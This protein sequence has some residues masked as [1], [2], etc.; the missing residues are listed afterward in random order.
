MTPLRVRYDW[1]ICVIGLIYACDMSDSSVHHDSC[2]CAPWLRHMC[3]M[4]YSHRWHGSLCAVCVCARVRVCVIVCE[5]ERVRVH[6]SMQGARKNFHLCSARE[7]F[8]IC[9]GEESFWRCSGKFFSPSPCKFCCTP[10][11]GISLSAH[12]QPDRICPAGGRGWEWGRTQGR[13]RGNKHNMHAR[14]RQTCHTHHSFLPLNHVGPSYYSY[15]NTY[16]NTRACNSKNTNRLSF[17][18][19]P[20]L[21]STHTQLKY[22]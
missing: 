7:S 2:V 20:F 11:V 1:F 21:I 3:D 16:P 15:P 10:F 5:R 19:A 14:A 17:S 13:V 18:L 22:Q 9:C 8:C 12:V 6:V 4:T